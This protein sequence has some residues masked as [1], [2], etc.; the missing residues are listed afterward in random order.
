[1]VAVVVLHN[2]HA[3][4]PAR[5]WDDRRELRPVRSIEG[6]PRI[7]DRDLIAGCLLDETT[8]AAGRRFK[9]DRRLQISPAVE[10]TA[11]PI[12][13][14]FAG[15]DV[16]A[17]GAGAR[18]FGIA[19]EVAPYGFGQSVDVVLDP[20]LQLAGLFKDCPAGSVPSSVEISFLA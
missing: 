19:F 17:L 9:S 6:E 20:R 13:T 11:E 5:I 4:D 7:N 2:V 12:D 18:S 16:V 15:N 3:R 8:A 14:V 1:M 10:S